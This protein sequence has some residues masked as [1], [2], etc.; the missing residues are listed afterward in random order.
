VK[1]DPESLFLKNNQFIPYLTILQTKSDS[2]SYLVEFRNLLENC[3]KDC[4]NE[5]VIKLMKKFFNYEGELKLI[6]KY[7][8]KITNLGLA[9]NDYFKRMISLYLEGGFLTDKHARDNMNIVCEFIGKATEDDEF[10]F[11]ADLFSERM[12]SSDIDIYLLARFQRDKDRS[13]DGSLFSI[14]PSDKVN[15][16][17][18]EVSSALYKCIAKIPSLTDAEMKN[19]DKNTDKFVKEATHQYIELREESKKFIDKYAKEA[20]EFMQLNQWGEL[21]HHIYGYISPDDFIPKKELNR[22][23]SIFANIRQNIQSSYQTLLSDNASSNIFYSCAELMVDSW[24]NLLFNILVKSFVLSNKKV[25]PTAF[26]LVQIIEAIIS[27]HIQPLGREISIAKIKKN[28]FFKKSGKKDIVA[29][30]NSCYIDYQAALKVQITGRSNLDYYLFCNNA[31]FRHHMGCHFSQLLIQVV[32]DKDEEIKE[33]NDKIKEYEKG[34]SVDNYNKEQVKKLSSENHKVESENKKLSEEIISLEDEVIFLKDKIFELERK[35]PDE[36]KVLKEENTYI[37][38]EQIRDLCDKHK[39]VFIGGHSNMISMINERIPNLY[40]L[41]SM[42]D[43]LHLK[44]EQVKN[45]DYVFTHTKHA[46]HKMYR[47]T[48]ELCERYNKPLIHVN[49][50]NLDLII[51]QIFNAITKETEKLA[52]KEVLKS[53]T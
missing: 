32:D 20:M 47:Y 3:N 31:I 36:E 48:K 53:A 21:N 45:C 18:E 37:T 1:N 17:Q 30:I 10:D 5:E 44:P 15:A 25:L 42:E 13:L 46:S 14:R 2:L 19:V 40:A 34:V 16:M 41:V 9:I 52:E 43:Y 26:D 50:N 27:Y 28:V 35:V 11:M 24:Y 7:E 39:V 22:H 12:N 33:L 29:F 49:I 51:L 6:G 38:N 4:V 23:M 8:A